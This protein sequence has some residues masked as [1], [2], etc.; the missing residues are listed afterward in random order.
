MLTAVAV[1]LGL[2]AGG[3][4]VALRRMAHRTRAQR[5]HLVR[6]LHEAREAAETSQRREAASLAALTDAQSRLETLETELEAARDQII[7]LDDEIEA[8]D[9]LANDQSAEL[10]SMAIEGEELRRRLASNELDMAS[11]RRDL[12]RLRSELDEIR[13]SPAR[14]AATI[15]GA[16]VGEAATLWRLELARSERTWRYSVAILPDD[17]S[18][19]ATT[20]DPLRLAIETEASALRD[21]VGAF[22]TVEV[23]PHLTADP[24]KAHLVLRLAQELLAQA[25]R[26]DEPSHLE[27]ARSPEGV[28][29]LAMRPVEEGD[30]LD[31]D[32]TDLALSECRSAEVAATVTP[33]GVHTITLLDA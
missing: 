2:L 12:E 5:Q 7:D 33:G 21:D 28:L 23:E 18:P 26:L 29:T 15:D 11:T 13:L 20:D 30:V 8:A 6:Q 32:L 9:Q 22:L 25:A 24:G 19:F 14:G 10:A 17:P 31:L 1:I 27:V 16:D 3:L 4:L